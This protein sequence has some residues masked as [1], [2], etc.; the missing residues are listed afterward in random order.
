MVDEEVVL[1]DDDEMRGV[2]CTT[3]GPS[4]LLLCWTSLKK[5]CWCVADEASVPSV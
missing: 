2:Q 4:S 1:E 5:T 3:V